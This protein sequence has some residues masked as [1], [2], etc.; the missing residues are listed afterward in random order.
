[1]ARKKK[2]GVAQLLWNFLVFLSTSFLHIFYLLALL[3]IKAGAFLLSHLASSAKKQREHAAQPK[4]DAEFSPLMLQ[5]AFTGD[6]RLF[7]S[8]IL[9]SKSTVGIALGARG[10]G[11]SAL[12][13]RMLENVSAKTGRKVCAMG[14]NQSALPSWII[15]VDEVSQIP[16]GA[17]VLVDEGGITF[18]SRSSMSSANKIL[19]SL[20]LVARH[21]DVSAIFISQNSANL[22]VNA[23]RQ[24]DYLLLRKPSLLQKDFERKIIGK[25]YDGMEKEF[26]S[27]PQNGRYSTYIYSDE[28]RGFASNG[29]PSFWSEKAS[30]GFENRKLA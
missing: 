21:K 14:F 9:S 25:I 4:S 2:G 10:S 8:R 12:G 23:I 15:P 24:A 16:N 27:L 26:D 30:K 29:I 5:K 28:F 11:K 18:S 13:M 22:E 19:S 1:M 17:F 3:A 20:L 6:L 7:E